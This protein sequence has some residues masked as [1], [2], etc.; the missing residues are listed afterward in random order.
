MTWS[1]LDAVMARI[2]GDPGSVTYRLISALLS[3][4][5]WLKDRCA[6]PR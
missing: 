4:K 2:Q 3:K 1:A 5:K 6:F